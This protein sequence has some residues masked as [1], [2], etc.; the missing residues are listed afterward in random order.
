MARKLL[1]K[2]LNFGMPRR[3]YYTLESV[4]RPYE[5]DLEFE[6]RHEVEFQSM[7]KAYRVR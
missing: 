7:L 1:K 2:L 5:S 4:Q 3:P 6:A